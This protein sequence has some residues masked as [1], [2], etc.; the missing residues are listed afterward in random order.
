[1]CA[2]AIDGRNVYSTALW[3][4]GFISRLCFAV[5][6]YTL[7]CLRG[8]TIDLVTR[9]MMFIMRLISLVL[10]LTYLEYCC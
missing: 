7:M 1:M 5:Y 3:L 9:L 4:P 2:V 10:V 6:G 8:L